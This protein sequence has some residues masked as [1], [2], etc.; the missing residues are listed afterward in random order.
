[1]IRGFSRGSNVVARLSRLFALCSVVAVGF[2]LLRGG[3]SGSNGPARPAKD[4][5]GEWAV[6]SIDGVKIPEGT[7]VTV[8]YT[9]DGRLLIRQIG[10]DQSFVLPDA[11]KLKKALDEIDPALA[12]SFGLKLRAEGFEIEL[13]RKPGTPVTIP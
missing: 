6:V 11:S 10:G 12:R 13:R 7:T 8:D 3:W 4:L 9:A 5:V 1:V 2:L